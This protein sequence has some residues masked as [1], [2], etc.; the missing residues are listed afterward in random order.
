MRK[1]ASRHRVLTAFVGAVAVATTVL[2]PYGRSAVN[3]ASKPSTPAGA[4]HIDK[5]ADALVKKLTAAGSRAAREKALLKLFGALHIGVYA[6]RTG[7]PIVRGRET[8]KDDYYVYDYELTLLVGALDRKEMRSLADVAQVLTNMGMKPKGQPVDPDMLRRALVA[9]V[10]GALHHTSD[11]TD[12]LPLLI[13]DLGLHHSPSYDLATDVPL[14]KVQLDALQVELLLAGLLGPEI[15]RIANTK[16]AHATFRPHDLSACKLINIAT[17]PFNPNTWLDLFGVHMH[18]VGDAAIAGQVSDFVQALTTAEHAVGAVNLAYTALSG[19]HGMLLAYSIKI[20]SLPDLHPITHYG[21]AG[22]GH[23]ADA[24]KPIVF[25]A[26][27][28]MQD[29]LGDKVVACLN[30]AGFTV[31]KKGPVENVP[32]DWH[33]NDEDLDSL[34]TITYQPANQKTGPDGIASMI[35]TPNGEAIPGFGEFVSKTGG[36]E[37][38]AL[39]G[40]AFENLL[41]TVNE[42][43]T[44]K[45]GEE[46]RWTVSLHRPRGFRFSGAVVR[47]AGEDVTITQTISGHVCGENPYAQPWEMTQ[48]GTTV[49]PQGSFTGTLDASP[50]LVPNKAV[51]VNMP[52]DD[53]TSTVQ[54]VPGRNLQITFTVPGPGGYAPASQTVSVAVQEDTTCPA[55]DD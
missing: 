19:L 43:I 52:W 46:Y 54:L 42:V 16:A 49:T 34:G 28:T 5:Q 33:I 1:N 29:D 15:H 13:R 30:S 2:L 53:M 11:G 51:N 55:N 4:I 44:P 48:Q 14:D 18:Y 41:G 47:W 27:V 9:L 32:I 35:F 38:R 25:R 7:Q 40:M 8:N 22:T 3:A 39:W 50:T 12:I 6:S 10:Q 20:E 17:S 24:G 26:R 45:L 36:A 23:E 31:P 21:P 37:P